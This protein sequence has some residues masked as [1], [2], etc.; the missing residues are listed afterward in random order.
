MCSKHTFNLLCVLT[1]CLGLAGAA[2]AAEAPQDQRKHTKLGKYATAV[3]SYEM[4][5]AAP[6]KVFIVDVRTPEE[7]DFLGH[8]DMAP[9][10]PSMF[11]T[12]TFDAQKKAYAMTMNPKFV[13]EM[14]RRFKPADT[15][16]LMCRSGH[17]SAAAANMLAASGFTNVYS[18]VDGFEGDKIADKASP[19]FGK[20]LLDG[21][22]NSKA[23]WTTDLDEKL[24][25]A[26]A[27]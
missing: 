3:E 24:V 6:G 2:L 19:A 7:Y 23:P 26:P 10:V 11:W 22:R 12:S 27:N 21:W 4:W 13:D 20:R 14:K 18:M 5:R 1:L 15:L 25:Y 17:R 8:P 16:V 9:N